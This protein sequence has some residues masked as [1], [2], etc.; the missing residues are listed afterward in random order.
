M[1][2]SILI[3]S[4]LQDGEFFNKCFGILKAQYFKD[5][6]DSQVFKLIKDYYAQYREKP[7]NVALVTMVKDIPNAETR[8]AIV[9]SL[10]R[11][12]KTEFNSNTEQMCNETVKF[13]KSSIFLK[14]LEVGSEG[15]MAKDESKMKKAQALM[16]EMNKVRIDSDLGLDFDDIESQIEYYSKREF[17]IK[18]QHKSFNKRLG[19]GFLPGTLNVILASQGVGKT[20]LMCDLISGMLMENKNILLVSLEMSQFEMLKRVQANVFDIDVNSFRDL[21]KTQGELQNLERPVTTKEQ[22]LSQYDKVKS[23]GK[24]GKLFIKE[25]PA[26]SIGAL[27]IQDLIEKFRTE[28]QITFDIVFIDYL[29]IM[30][31]DLV[32]PSAGL[33]SYVKSITEEVRALAVKNQIACISASQLNRAAVNKT[34][35]IDNSA[36]SDS[37]STAATSDWLCFILQNEEMKANSEV[38]VKITKNRYTGITDSFVMNIDYPK[39]RFCEII[40]NQEV[41]DNALVPFT[42][43]EQKVNAESFAKQAI[44][45][46]SKANQEIAKKFNSQTISDDELN[47]LLGI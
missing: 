37:Y 28:K 23:S 8:K 12:S 10:E 40:E 36:I 11:V 29:G 15:L 22:I 43:V 27:G 35:G 3:K 31:S 9:Q 39:M 30:K 45:E 7:S 13:I 21:A 34:E 25:Y 1:F 24:C 41:P 6:G 33:Y 20:L 44:I 16:E 14:G 42:S 19:S 32:S 5:F 26:G 47:A 46:D 2:E 4:L 17:G 38:L 18:T